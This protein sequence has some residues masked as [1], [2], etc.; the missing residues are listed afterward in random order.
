MQMQKSALVK[1]DRKR[2]WINHEKSYG[3]GHSMAKK[4]ID[5]PEKIIKQNGTKRKI[6]QNDE[7]KDVDL[8]FRKKKKVQDMFK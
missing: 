5:K 2:Y 1:L 7:P 4:N 6:D 8:T 3:Y